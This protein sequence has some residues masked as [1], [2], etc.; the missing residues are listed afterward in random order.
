MTYASTDTASNFDAEKFRKV[1]VMMDRGATDGERA[2]ARTRAE[3]MAQRAG[4]T[5]KQAMSKMDRKAKAEAPKPPPPSNDDWRN[6]FRDIF[7]DMDDEMEAKEPGYKARKAKKKAER[8]AETV[9]R[10]KEALK[11]HGSAGAIFEL[12]DIERALYEAATPFAKREWNDGWIEGRFAFTQELGGH[13]VDFWPEKTPQFVVE[14]I[15]K[16]WPMPDTI[17]GLLAEVRM[18]DDLSRLRGLFVDGEYHHHSEVTVREWLVEEELNTRPAAS[19]DDVSARFEWALYK[20]QRQWIE[21]EAGG[22]DPFDERL[23]QD[24]KIL[25][26]KYEAR[27]VADTPTR[28]TNA[29]KRSDVLSMMDANPD[30]SDREISRRCGVSPQTVCNWRHKRAEGASA[31]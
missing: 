7:R 4:M 8:D 3:A 31:A 17:V 18:W 16:A 19:W 14:V 29:D 21:P 22:L 23:R 20:E 5:L 9:R 24:F 30:L 10:K 2:A 13:N 28:R 15:R 6:T 1:R 12:T 26:A 11:A 27:P 25:R